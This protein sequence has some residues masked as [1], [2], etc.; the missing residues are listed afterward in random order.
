MTVIS[1]CYSSFSSP[2]IC[3]DMT[4]EGGF[5]LTEIILNVCFC[6]MQSSCHIFHY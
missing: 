4:D 3:P 5:L 2:Y 6:K 1:H